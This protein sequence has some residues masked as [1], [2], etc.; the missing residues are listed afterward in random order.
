MKSLKNETEHNNFSNVW[1]F[2]PNMPNSFREI[3]F[4]KPQTLQRMTVLI[5][6]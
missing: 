4:E 3:L 2:E 5:K 1:K 6:L